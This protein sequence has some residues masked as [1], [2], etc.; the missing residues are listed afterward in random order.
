M[1]HVPDAAAE[2]LAAEAAARVLGISAATA[3]VEAI[4]GGA[5]SRSFLVDFG[6]ACVFAKLPNASVGLTLAPALEHALLER[7]AASGLTPQPLGLDTLSGTIVSAYATTAR[8]PSAGDLASQNTLR[9]IARTLRELHA[10][11]LPLRA[12]EPLEFA[13]HYVSSALPEACVAAQRML[14]EVQTL[15][16]RSA[17]AMIGPGICHNDLHAGNI[18][19]EDTPDGGRI[20]FTDFEYA[21]TA[22]PM[23][24]IASFAALNRLPLDAVQHLI[25]AYH[26]ETVKTF[27]PEAFMDLVR[28]HEII[29]DLW[30]LARNDNN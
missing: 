18:L 26:G 1:P 14:V 29:A 2:Q 12:F 7:L 24:D 15:A 25:D 20:L 10:I 13:Q 21:V 11:E 3:R 30:K 19:I 28:M 16:T 6:S 8:T 17:A 4:A 5:V 23:V 9:A 27:D 22:A